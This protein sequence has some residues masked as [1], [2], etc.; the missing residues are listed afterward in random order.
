MITIAI[1]IIKQMKK[2]K[3]TSNEIV[4]ETL[5]LF[6]SLFNDGFSHVIFIAS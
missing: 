4:I 1:I 2:T 5:T 3:T 6:T